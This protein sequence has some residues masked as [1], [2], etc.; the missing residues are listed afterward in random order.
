MGLSA[1][2]LELSNGIA[3]QPHRE[4]YSIENVEVALADLA[5]EN[6]RRHR[7]VVKPRQY[8]KN[9]EHVVDVVD[10][11]DG[12]RWDLAKCS[13][14]STKHSRF[15]EHLN[16]DG[17]CGHYSEQSEALAPVSVENSAHRLAVLDVVVSV[18][19]ASAYWNALFWTLF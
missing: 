4:T 2:D 7:L 17:D 14:R 11:F 12:D 16:P 10:M 6:S 3:R 8:C 9:C 19:G 1:S 18:C 13:V 15:C 5:K